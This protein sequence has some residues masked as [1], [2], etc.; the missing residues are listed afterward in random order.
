MN[1][2]I[3]SQLDHDLYFKSSTVADESPLEPG[4][5]LLPADSVDAKPPVVP[6]GKRAK[7]NGAAFVFEDLPKPEPTPE[8][9]PEQIA[10][11]VRNARQIAYMRESDPLFFKAQRGEATMDEW[12]AKVEEIKARIPDGVI[13]Y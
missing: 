6:S 1:Q 12:A 13:P 2:K 5:Y 9:T 3:V 7:W 10:E 4:V 11:A 8:P